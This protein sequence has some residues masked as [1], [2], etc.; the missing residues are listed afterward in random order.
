MIN[1]KTNTNNRSKVLDYIL[2]VASGALETLREK[3]NTKKGMI[4]FLIILGSSILALT[5]KLNMETVEK[6]GPFVEK[7][8]NLIG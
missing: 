5:G 4:N 3:L 1:N 6:I 8:F 2:S 7:V